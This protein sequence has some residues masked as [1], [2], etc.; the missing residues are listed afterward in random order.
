M[1]RR[2]ADEAGGLVPRTWDLLGEDPFF[3]PLW[4]NPF[5][6]MNDAIQQFENQVRVPGVPRDIPVDVVEV[7]DPS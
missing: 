4:A 1:I 2:G 5:R 6:G 7:R 3:G